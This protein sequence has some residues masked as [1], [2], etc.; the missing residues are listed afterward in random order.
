MMQKIVLMQICAQTYQIHCN[1]FYLYHLISS[2]TFCHLVKANLYKDDSFKFAKFKSMSYII[3]SYDSCLLFEDEIRHVSSNWSSDR[4]IKLQWTNCFTKME[5]VNFK[6]KRIRLM[7]LIA[8][9]STILLL[10]IIKHG[11]FDHK[12]A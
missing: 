5:Q 10:S 12:T 6:M 3:P 8:L 9:N 7:A 11:V 2:N 1:H 4:H